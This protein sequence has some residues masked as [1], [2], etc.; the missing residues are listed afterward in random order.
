MFKSHFAYSCI[1]VMVVNG[2]HYNGQILK[3]LS[4]NYHYS[5]GLF[6]FTDL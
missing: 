4:P 6:I 3:R 1:L 5:M 2:G